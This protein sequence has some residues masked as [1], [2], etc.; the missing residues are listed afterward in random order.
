MSPT[1]LVLLGIAAV[2]L[3]LF[4]II[5]AKTHPFIAM[6]LVSIALALAARVPLSEVVPLL[7]D[8]MGGT[9]GGVALIVTLGAM[10][11]RIVEVSGG[12]EVLARSLE[13]NFGEKR[14]PWALGAASFIFG[15]PVFVDVATIVL[16]PI[17]LAVARRMGGKTNMLAYALPVVAALLTVH[18]VLP[19]HPG[20]V[21][22]SELMQADVG[23]VLL[24]GLIPAVVMW[25]VGQV[26]SGFIV[27]KVFSPVPAVGSQA[28]GTT[29]NQ[30]VEVDDGGAPSVGLV[31]A[32]ILLPLVLIMGGTVSTLML[33]EGT[34]VRDFLGFVGDSPI[35]LFIG[36][37]FATG[38]LGFARGWGKEQVEDV[39]ASALPATAAVILITGAGGTFGKVLTETGVADAVADLLV[40]TGLPVLVLA[41]LLAAFIRAAQGSAT[42]AALTTAPLVAPMI[43]SLE[44]NGL[45]VALVTVTVGIG[46]MA[47][48]HVNDS[49]FWVWSRYFQVDTASALK[50]YTVTTTIM[51]I[52]GFVVVG[53]LWLVLGAMA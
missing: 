11:G 2:A 22:A 18:V 12:A 9:L 45:Q 1:T 6:L 5:R 10:L 8:G 33:D 28:A 25:L 13:K 53:I 40:S 42:V 46:S 50:S 16:V 48:S 37:I 39:V 32:T 7:K 41:W 26:F 24:L 29:A 49:L 52:V 27:K 21:G 17:T 36:V 20:I 31:L 43:A 47:F 34:A 38:V 15:I 14:A 51:S 30:D 35:A 19:P 4:L 3:I 23:M 44:L